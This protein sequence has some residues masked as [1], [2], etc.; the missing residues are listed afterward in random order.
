MTGR[1]DRT[2]VEDMVEATDRILRYTAGTEFVDFVADERTVDAV[3]RNLIVLGE[4]A[5]R[6]GD[7]TRALGPDVEWGRI[8]RSRHIAVH[9]YFGVDLDIV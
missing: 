4:A 2:R 7:D 3:L 9:D 8:V 5:A 1:A 6:T